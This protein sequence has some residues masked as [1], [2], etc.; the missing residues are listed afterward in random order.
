ML[1]LAGSNNYSGSTYITGGTLALS[2][3]GSIVKSPLISVAAGAVLDISGASSP[4]LGSSQTLIGNGSVNGSLSFTGGTI[5]PG[6]VGTAGTLTFNNDLN[7]NGGVIQLDLSGASNVSGGGI[8]DLINITGNLAV[9]AVTPIS[10]SFTGSPARG[11][12]YWVITSGTESGTLSN[13][14]PYQPDTQ[15][16]PPSPTRWV[17]S[18]PDQPGPIT[19][20]GTQP[21]A[22]TGI[23][24]FHTTGSIWVPVPATSSS[25]TTM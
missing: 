24:G 12:E 22:A 8:N 16:T 15:W 23:S 14:I 10:V 2:G 6:T 9:N 3:S 4:S 7:A 20:S 1:T 25:P 11:T 13:L 18:I 5:N 17:S 21:A 19:W